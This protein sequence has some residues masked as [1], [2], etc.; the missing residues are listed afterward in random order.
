MKNNLVGAALLA[1]ALAA[2]PGEGYAG[3]ITTPTPNDSDSAQSGPPD[4]GRA[5]SAAAPGQ[6]A[7]IDLLAPPPRPDAESLR[8]DVDPAAVGADRSQSLQQLQKAFAAEAYGGLQKS[9]DLMGQSPRKSGAI[10]AKSGPDPLRDIGM[11][12]KDYM[13]IDSVNG[14]GEAT[15]VKNEIVNGL[16][17]IHSSLDSGGG[18]PAWGQG[19]GRESSSYSASSGASMAADTSRLAP[20][21]A[22]RMPD[23]FLETLDSANQIV[24]FVRDNR[25][26]ALV[27]V[28]MTFGAISMVRL[29]R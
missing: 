5:D 23:W 4:E 19:D 12:V 7:G 27:L 18:S 11:A 3:P 16:K 8:K 26:L 21:H 28:A 17:A 2:Y 10:P 6:G 29:R 1:A 13:Q 22:A 14:M 20:G 24:N 25:V 9:D 15:G